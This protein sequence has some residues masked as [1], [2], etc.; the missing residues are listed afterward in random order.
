MG[1]ER[2]RI[3]SAFQ[4]GANQYD[5]HTPV[6]QR[7]IERLFELLKEN[8]L[9]DFAECLDVGC[10]TGRLLELIA[11]Q[12]P[13]FRLTGLDLAD[14]ML[15]QAAARLPSSVCLLQ[16]DA[17]K[18]PFSD[19][20]F[21]LLL[22]SST[23]QWLPSLPK[24]FLELHRVIRPG[25]SVAFSMFGL[26]TLVELQDSWRVALDRLGKC[27]GSAHDGT[28]Q[29]YSVAQVQ[30]ALELAGFTN[31]KVWA[32]TEV[33]YYPDVSHLLRAIKKIGAG[34]ARPPSGG[35]L[36]WRAVLQDMAESYRVSYA[37][38]EGIPASYGVIYATGSR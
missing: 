7:I 23:F 16:G 4:R 1:V 11:H 32:E 25:G 18:L 12:F 37:T 35:G 9:P 15:L 33:A 10:G 29:F 3:Q 28:H 14:Q 5:Q 36:G 34:T 17:E 13:H 2:K 6:Q 38:P 19:G 31:V 8:Q 24:C 22:S 27:T 26:G 20:C 30:S 21:D